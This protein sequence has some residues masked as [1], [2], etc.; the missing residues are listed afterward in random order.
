MIEERC[1][2]CGLG[3]IYSIYFIPYTLESSR[4][5]ACCPAVC[6]SGESWRRPPQS[7]LSLNSPA[8]DFVCYL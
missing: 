3:Y 7:L 2:F 1:I 5:E 4:M 6:L 8:D